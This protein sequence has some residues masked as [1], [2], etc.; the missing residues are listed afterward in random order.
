[1][2]LRF[3]RRIKLFPRVRLNLARSGVSTGIGGRGAHV[4]LGHG[5]VRETVDQPSF[6]REAPPITFAPPAPVAAKV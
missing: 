6:A 3:H 2:S 4:T 1:M 5:R